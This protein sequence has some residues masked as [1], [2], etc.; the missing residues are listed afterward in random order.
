M[1]LLI[2]FLKSLNSFWLLLHYPV[3]H[4]TT[5]YCTI[6]PCPAVHCPAL[7]CIA[8][9]CMTM[10]YTAVQLRTSYTMQYRVALHY[11]AQCFTARPLLYVLYSAVQCSSALHCTQLSTLYVLQYFTLLTNLLTLVTNLTG[12]FLRRGPMFHGI[13]R[14]C[15]AV[16]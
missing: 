3:L 4:Y 6:L 13:G 14:L 10:H 15:L 1:S 7:H 12:H 2:A 8:L 16:G 11:I 5:I 9:H